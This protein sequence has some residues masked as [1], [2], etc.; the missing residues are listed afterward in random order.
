MATDPNST[1][2]NFWPEYLE[3]HRNPTNRALH[4]AGTLSAAALLGVGLARRDWRALVAAPLVGYGA[5]W[6]GHF[7]VERNRPKTLDAPLASLAADVRM[8]GLAIT[9]QLAREYRRYGIPDRPG[10]VI[11]RHPPRAPALEPVPSDEKRG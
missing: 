1:D 7:L 9:G 4:V 3:Q 2:P 11:R 10:L 8:A 5:A 6:L